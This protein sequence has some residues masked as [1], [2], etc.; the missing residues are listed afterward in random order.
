[1]F[2]VVVLATFCILDLIWIHILKKVFLVFLSR[3]VQSSCSK[4]SKCAGMNKIF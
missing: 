1:M 4:F 2:Q 3:L